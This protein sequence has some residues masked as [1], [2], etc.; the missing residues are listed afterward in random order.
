MMTLFEMMQS[1]QNGQAMQNLARQYGLSQQQTQSAIDALLPAFSMGL[2]RQTQDPYAFGNL[3]QMM[4]AS[5]FAKMY[6]ADGDGIPDNA[7]TMGNDVLSQLFGSK[8]VSNAVTAQAA[9]TSGV[10]QAIL[11]QMLPVIASMV[12]GG[13]FKSTNNQG[14]GG[15]LG[16]FAEM[17]QGKM[18]GQQPAPQPQAQPNPANPLDAIL[19]GLFGNGQVPGPGQTQGGGPFG[20]GQMPGGQLGSDQMGGILGQI[21]T[22][23]LGGAQQQPQPDATTAPPQPRGRAAP[24][25]QP[26]APAPS[27]ETGA[28]SIGLDALNQMFEHG[29][30]V[31]DG[32]QNALKS[33]L[34][35][36]LGGQGRR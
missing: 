14:M 29:R 19:G 2:Q 25:P 5:P 30:Q 13:L 16:Q 7:R 12:M 8:E 32:H 34:D 17:M 27:T 15:V 9:A 20:G 33:I 3:A 28:G 35:A 4:T 6:D 1:A 31:Q 18:P 22:G 10:G 21:L 26:D 24:E 11:K 23:M 36:M